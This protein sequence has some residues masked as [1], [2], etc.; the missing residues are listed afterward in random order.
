MLLRIVLILVL[1]TSDPRLACLEL[2]VSF[3]SSFAPRS[4]G[5][6]SITAQYYWYHLQSLA[7]FQT[8]KV[9]WHAPLSA[10]LPCLVVPP[11]LGRQFVACATVRLHVP[12]AQFAVCPSSLVIVC[13][14]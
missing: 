14:V 12:H 8:I 3:L 6:Y 9:R 7:V 13:G 1:V 10:D 2:M 11:L 4:A 5:Y